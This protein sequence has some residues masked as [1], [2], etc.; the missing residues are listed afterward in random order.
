MSDSIIKISKIDAYTVE[1]T[2]IVGISDIKHHF[3]LLHSKNND[4]VIEFSNKSNIEIDLAKLIV[5]CHDSGISHAML[6]LK[7][8]VNPDEKIYRM[9]NENG[10]E[11]MSY[12]EFRR[13]FNIEIENGH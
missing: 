12:S 7:D 6:I 1:E 8:S 5:K 9:A 4:V 10:I 3:T 11:I 2:E 13:R